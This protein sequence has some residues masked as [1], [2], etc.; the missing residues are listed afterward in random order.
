MN[1]YSI[2]NDELI[3]IK[4]VD[5]KLEKDIQKITERNID[6]LFKLELVKSEFAINNF[7]IDTLTYDQESNSFVIIEYKRDRN[8][9]VV[10]QGYAYLSLML[11]N[12]AD[13]I[14]E[15]NENKKKS[16]KRED[17]DWSQ[18]RVMF[19]APSFTN[20]QIESINFKDLPIELWQIK[21]F[22]NN[23]IMYS[24]ILSSNAQESIKTISHN[25]DEVKK[26]N[27]EIKVY[28]ENEHLSKC[29]EEI[30]ELYEKFKEH[31]QSIGEIEIKPK[32][33]YIAFIAGSNIVD[34]HPQKKSLKLWIN[35]SKGKLDD[36]KNITR[37]V[38]S[39]G[40]WG[41]GDYEIQVSDD[42]NIE[43]ILSLIKQSLKRNRK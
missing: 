21:T 4:E 14:L 23:T 39:I 10:D 12:K 5:F 9:S 29:S 33:K 13:F 42:E 15:Y 28:T 24:Q 31:I 6:L 16:L 26:I 8:F 41:N 35:L 11:N 7:R 18:S 30:R 34:I 3:L 1:L 40:H 25:A 17:V 38:S 37:D 2:S 22:D 32:K 19:I 43:Y 27:K 20:Y 36:P